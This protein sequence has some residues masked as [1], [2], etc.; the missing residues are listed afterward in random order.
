MDI[1]NPLA[2]SPSDSHSSSL[3]YLEPGARSLFQVS[4]MGAELQGFC[5]P[6]TAFSGHKQ[7]L[8]GK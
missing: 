6:I 3:A 5:P 2:H 8:G 7:K 1:L 4:H